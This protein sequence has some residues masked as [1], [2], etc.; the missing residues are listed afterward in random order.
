MKRFSAIDDNNIYRQREMGE[1]LFGVPET[2]NSS[3]PAINN[4][5]QS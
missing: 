5:V 2:L 4:R 1:N 3:A